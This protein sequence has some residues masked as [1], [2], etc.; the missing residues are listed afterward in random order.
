MLNSTYTRWLGSAAISLAAALVAL[1]AYAGAA[2]VDLVGRKGKVQVIERNGTVQEVDP[3]DLHINTIRSKSPAP[4]TSKS[5]S[6][7]DD[8][9][10]QNSDAQ[11][12]D[13]QANG[14]QPGTAKDK[15]NPAD[16]KSK[17]STENAQPAQ[18]EL[19]PEQIAARKKDAEAVRKMLDTGGAYFY[20]DDNTPLSY[21]E[22]KK[23]V[24]SNNVEGIKAL[25]LWQQPWK[26]ASSPADGESDS[27]S[28]GSSQPP[29]KE[30]P[31]SAR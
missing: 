3:N 20:K 12:E 4:A 16:S 8:S 30:T 6:P 11:P 21:E 17:S 14:D 18:K 7:K 24:D 1:P 22:V 9:G 28:S 25:D 31:A 27:D 29:A 13:S 26:S 10:V 15:E 19:T 5:A 23:M 2:T